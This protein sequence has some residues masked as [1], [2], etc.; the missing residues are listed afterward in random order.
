[1]TEKRKNGKWLRVCRTSLVCSACYWYCRLH[2]H[3]GWHFPTRSRSAYE[4]FCITLLCPVSLAA[5]YYLFSSTSV[6]AIGRVTLVTDQKYPF[7]WLLSISCDTRLW[8]SV[9]FMLLMCF[10]YSIYN[11]NESRGRCWHD[12]LL[13]RN[14]NIGGTVS[15]TYYLLYVAGRRKGGEGAETS[16][17][18]DTMI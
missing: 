9:F 13:A 12:W 2:S 18:R 7:C 3:D 4:F 10:L 8:Y 6:F 15:C 5:Y 16:K 11:E 14:T 17:I 1:M